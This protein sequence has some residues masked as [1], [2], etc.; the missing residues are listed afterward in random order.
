MNLISKPIAGQCNVSTKTKWG[1]RLAQ[2]NILGNQS[3]TSIFPIILNM[4][5]IFDQKNP[6]L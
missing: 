3:N 5:L 2:V 6:V 1:Y 4:M